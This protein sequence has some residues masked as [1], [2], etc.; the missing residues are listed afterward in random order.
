AFWERQGV[1]HRLDKETSGVLLLAKKPEVFVELLR[2]FREREV[3]KTYFALV[4]GVPEVLQGQIN[5]PIGRLPWNRLRFGVLAG[6]RDAVSSYRVINMY[7]NVEVA[8]VYGR[9]EF[10]L[11]EVKPHTGRTHQIRVHMQYLGT[12]IVGDELYCGRKL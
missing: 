5:A 3:K 1:V 11:V 2:A 7:K 6:G 8:G 12:P 10:A 4:H 9:H